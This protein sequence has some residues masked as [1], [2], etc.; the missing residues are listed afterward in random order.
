MMIFHWVMISFIF[1]MTHGFSRFLLFFWHSRYIINRLLLATSAKIQSYFSDLVA[2]KGRSY[3]RISPFLWTT[4]VIILITPRIETL[5]LKEGN[6]VYFLAYVTIFHALPF[7]YVH[8]S[9]CSY[10]TIFVWIPFFICYIHN[11]PNIYLWLV[12]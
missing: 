10:V 2:Y 4:S 8:I 11:F 6:H 7:S 1:F 3:H 9:T 5:N 12:D